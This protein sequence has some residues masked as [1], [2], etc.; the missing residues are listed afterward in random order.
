[1]DRTK[2]IEWLVA[3]SDCWKSEK[4]QAALNELEDDTIVSLYD[5]EQRFHSVFNALKQPVEIGGVGVKLAL[6][7][8]NELTAEVLTPVANDEEEEEEVEV[9]NAKKTDDAN[10]DDDDFES[11]EFEKDEDEPKKMKKNAEKVYTEEEWLAAAPPRLKAVF[12]TALE[13]DKEAKSAIVEKLVANSSSKDEDRKEF[14]K[15]D[16]KKLRLIEKNLPTANAATTDNEDEDETSFLDYTLAAGGKGT[17]TNE[18]VEEPLPV[19]TFN[20]ASAQ[21]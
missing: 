6:N 15:L 9:E 14:M 2:R 10:D 18:E 17:V 16:L 7:D 1:M 12:N 3:N 20:Y 8:Q 13:L 4:A 11:E 5:Q 19:P 21:K